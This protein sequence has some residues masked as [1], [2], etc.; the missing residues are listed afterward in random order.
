MNGARLPLAGL[1]LVVVSGL[2]IMAS[3]PSAWAYDPTVPEE[4]QDAG[5]E[6]V[7]EIHL[8]EP[9]P[10]YCKTRAD[11]DDADEAVWDIDQMVEEAPIEEIKESVAAQEGMVILPDGIQSGVTMA[12][13]EWERSDPDE[14]VSLCVDPEEPDGDFVC[15]RRNPEIPAFTNE[16]DDSGVFAK[17][18]WD[19]TG[20]RQNETIGEAVGDAVEEFSD[21][22]GSMVDSFATSMVQ[23]FK[24]FL[25]TTL[26][27]WLGVPHPEVEETGARVMWPVTLGLGVF[28]GFFMIVFQ[29]IKMM[30]TRSPGVL[31]Y[32]VRGCI[33]FMVVCACGVGV[34]H[35][36][37]RGSEALTDGIV[38]WAVNSNVGC[39]QF[40]QEEFAPDEDL[41]FPAL[42]QQEGESDDEHAERSGM[43]TSF[44]MCAA[45]SMVTTSVGGGAMIILYAVAL[46]MSLVQGLLLFVRE[47]AL[48]ILVLLFPIAAAGQLGPA[49]SRRWLPNVIA[50]IAT[51]LAYKPMVALIFAVGFTTASMS[52]GI[53]DILRGLL[54]LFLGVVAPGVMLKAF[55][56]LAASA[57]EGAGSFGSTVNNLFMASQM[58]GSVSN[59]MEKQAGVRAAQAAQQHAAKQA[60]GEGGGLVLSATK[61]AAG[62]GATAAA[63]PVG[64]AATAAQFLKDGVKKV[65]GKS[66]NPTAGAADHTV[67][68][69]SVAQGRT[70]SGEA[71]GLRTRTPG[72]GKLNQPEAASGLGPQ[73]HHDPVPGPVPAQT[74]STASPAAASSPAPHEG[75]PTPPTPPGP[76]PRPA[77]DQPGQSP[78]P[79]QRP[80]VDPAQFTP[81]PSLP[82]GSEKD[83]S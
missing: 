6:Q 10:A 1:L 12:G 24:K 38:D 39:T 56:P 13:S 77:T 75:P 69:R 64:W 59:W 80:S 9:F 17:R 30:I 2:L 25:A 79:A 4:L 61:G 45:S 40:N 16:R 44:A 19:T 65:M 47:S 57:V 23:G 26:F 8:G 70:A 67:A 51:M 81:P 50:M 72:Q 62:K 7:T 3:P 42:P 76:Q 31:V 18:C 20:H 83:D 58:G 36:L 53:V 71:A 63:G 5:Y 14:Y 82:N 41:N 78:E 66:A 60:A 34:T 32:L 22:V 55:K 54:I 46:L 35:S 28:I 15:F 29:A 73:P 43:A 48:P 68:G 21:P 33:I 11:L 52:P 27:W 37:S 74:P 49:S